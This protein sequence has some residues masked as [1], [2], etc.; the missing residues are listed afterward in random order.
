MR[1]LAIIGLALWTMSP[2]LASAT[3]D[4]APIPTPPPSTAKTDLRVAP[5]APAWGAV[6]RP[7]VQGDI[8]CLTKRTAT[9]I[10]GKLVYLRLYPG[11]CQNAMDNNAD[12]FR[13]RCDGQRSVDAVKCD[14]KV[15]ATKAAGWRPLE[16]VG[17]A[18][19]ALAAGY[20]AG[21]LIK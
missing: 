3:T 14:S 19:V 1:A 6:D 4:D 2:R 13:Q 21:K 7:T 18:A 10:H 8:T 20:A 15:E 9:E 16:I 5:P 12:V 17:V 11:L